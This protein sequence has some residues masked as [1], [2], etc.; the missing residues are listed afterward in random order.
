MISV[1]LDVDFCSFFFFFVILRSD[2][3]LL[4]FVRQIIFLCVS[5][6]FNAANNYEKFYRQPS[7]MQSLSA[8][9]WF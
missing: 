5:N 2:N 9:T 6:V 3:I 7:K 4:K 8:V 1:Q